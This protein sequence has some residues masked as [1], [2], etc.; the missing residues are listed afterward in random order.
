MEQSI[1]INYADVVRQIKNAILQSRYRAAKLANREMLSLYFGIGK[2]ISENSRNHF[3][4]TGA[5]ESISERLQQE[6][7]GLRGFSPANIKRMRQFYEEWQPYLITENHI[8]SIR[9]MLSDEIQIDLLAANRPTV[10]DD[11]EMD[12]WNSFLSVGFSHHY[13]III[14]TKTLEERFFYIGKCATEFWNY[15]VLQ[16]NLKSNLFAKQGKL[17]N[18]FAI[19]IS[20]ADLRRKAL[21]SFKDEYL[22]DYINI[23]SPDDEVDERVLESEIVLNIKNFIMSLGKDFAFIGNQHR[24]IVEDREYF[25]DLLFFNRQLQCLVAIDLKRGEFKPEYLGKMNFYL[26][27]LDDLVR[28]PHENRS[29]GIILCKS[30]KEKIVEYALRDT[31]KPMG[32]ATYKLATELPEKYRGVL[33]DAEELRRLM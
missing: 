4:G 30:K 6:L 21:L 9:P 27:A 15:R 8:Q 18:N 24:F 14:K 13:E 22:L 33:P 29:I 28:L 10:S 12:T 3:W 2:F 32:V 23:E 17:P 25:V 5:I 26:S 16:N 20:D 11:L 19:T 1:S 7:P 31:S